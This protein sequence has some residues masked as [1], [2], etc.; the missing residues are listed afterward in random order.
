MSVFLAGLAEITITPPKGVSMAGFAARTGTAA[1]VHDDL[2][3]VALVLDDRRQKSA[4]CAVDVVGVS[5]VLVE[6]VRNRVSYKTA[7][8]PERILIAATHNHSGPVMGG[9]SLRSQE[10]LRELEDRLVHVIQDAD[11]LRRGARVGAA[12]GRAEGVGGNRRDPENGAVDRSVNVLRVDDARTGRILG[13]VVNHACHATTLG[14]ENVEFTADYPGQTREHIRE[15]LED[16]PVALFLNGA[17]GDVNPGGYSAEASALGK[18]IPN[19]TFERAEEIGRILG[20][21]AV[22]LVR[23][24]ETQGPVHVQAGRVEVKL[25]VNGASL[26]AE[27]EEALERK[28]RKLD[29]LLRAGAAEEEADAAR[30]D[31]MYARVAVGH[32]RRR[33]E[34]PNSEMTTELQGIAVHDSL[35]LAFPGEMFTQI[36]LAVKAASPFERTFIVGYA[37]DTAGYFPSVEALSEGGYEVKASGFGPVAIQRITGWANRLAA[38]IHGSLRTAVHESEHA[39]PPPPRAVPALHVPEHCP[40]QARFPMIDFLLHYWSQ[41]H[42]LD[43]A[44]A[45]MDATNTRFGVV[46]VGDAFPKAELEPAMEMFQGGAPRF[47]HFTGFDYRGIDGPDWPEYVREKLRHDLAL[48]ARGIKIYKELGLRHRDSAGRLIAPDDPRLQPVWP[49]PFSRR[50]SSERRTAAVSSGVP[51]NVNWLPG[52]RP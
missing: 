45:D 21:E 37:N 17:C 50:R 25:P 34:C 43:E 14:A 18:I 15:N 12:S 4:I 19:R 39:A 7:I 23:E 51:R 6:S 44:V 46:Q 8:A 10:W 27:A 29:A 30:L 38:D 40:Q 33:A 5:P 41:W 47:F 11:R 22:R 42:P 49:L 26:P 36:G 24:I 48:G 2:K 9:D 32:A 16:R 35:F 20:G 3:A 52:C 1:G 31:V 13:V 28:R